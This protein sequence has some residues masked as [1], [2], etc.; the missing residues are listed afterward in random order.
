MPTPEPDPRIKDAIDRVLTLFEKKDWP[1]QIALVTFP[2]SNVPMNKWS[3]FN[4]LTTITNGTHDARGYN[5]WQKAGR[6]V[7]KGSTAIYIL[8]PSMKKYTE[9][10]YEKDGMKIRVTKEEPA[11]DGAEIKSHTKDYVRGFIGIPVF[12]YEDTDGKPLDIPE[13]KLPELRYLS[14]AKNLGITVKTQP[15]GQNFY[16]YYSASRKEIVLASPDAVVFYHELAH[17]VDDKLLKD[18]GKKLVGGQQPD[19]EIV[20]EMSSIILAQLVGENIELKS[21]KQGIDY[22]KRYASIIGDDVRTSAVKLLSRIEGIVDY[23]TKNE[24]PEINKN[25]VT[26]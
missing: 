6:Y 23:I 7:K 2:Q 25:A 16:G 3:L 22:I 11:P 24:T 8:A 4:R 1:E 26:A 21:G 14:V 20:A 19:Q 9:R 13:L 12:K 10:Y 15:G 18:R 17:A 5:Q